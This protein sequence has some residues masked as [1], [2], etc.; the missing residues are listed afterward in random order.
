[1]Q[2]DKPSK[3]NP[4]ETATFIPVLATAG[5][6]SPLEDATLT[7][8]GVG[9]PGNSFKYGQAGVTVVTATVSR[10]LNASARY[11]YLSSRY[12]ENTPV[13]SGGSENYVWMDL[14][15]SNS[16]WAAISPPPVG[17]CW[18]GALSYTVT[19]LSR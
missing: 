17:D 15:S 7:L 1:M 6:G 9:L 12:T 14:E 3:A 16:N 11:T 8:T 2:G 10:W 4:A 18:E 5:Y 13:A 19:F